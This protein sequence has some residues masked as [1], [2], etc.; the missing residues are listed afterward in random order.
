MRWG[1]ERPAPRR[2]GP[3]GQYA[4]RPGALV[5]VK[6]C[7]NGYPLP[8]GLEPGERVKI[9]GFDHG[10]YLVERGGRTFTIFMANIIGP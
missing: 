7:A 9:L 4:L 2:Y 6:H 8:P 10:Y 1:D 5:R 3:A